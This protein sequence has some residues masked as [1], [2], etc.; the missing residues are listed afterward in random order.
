V[1]AL[2]KRGG[3]GAFSFLGLCLLRRE[4]KG[5][6]GRRREGA[7][8]F[9]GCGAGLEFEGIGLRLLS[10]ADDH[11]VFQKGGAV[12]PP[13][14]AA[15]APS[16]ANGRAASRTWELL[17]LHCPFAFRLRKGWRLDWLLPTGS[18]GST[19]CFHRHRW[20]SWLDYFLALAL[21]A[22]PAARTG[23]TGPAVCFHWLYWLPPRA[24]LARPAAPTG[25][26]DGL[27]PLALLAWLVARRERRRRWWCRR[28]RRWWRWRRWRR[29]QRRRWWRHLAA[30]AAAAAAALVAALA[31]ALV[32]P[33]AKT[34]TGPYFGDLR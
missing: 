4:E 6:E 18:A 2:E 27:L 21:L 20:L 32:A 19:A 17:L 11:R 5:V 10:V 3:G 22:R 8:E 1:V 28:R 33:L 25:F 14:C 9:L 13:S 26:T 30:L 12:F 29:Q 16:N 23:S 15:I 31:A 34:K 24:L 7:F